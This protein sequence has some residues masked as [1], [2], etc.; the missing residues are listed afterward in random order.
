MGSMV[1][2]F[3][4]ANK[5]T[6]LRYFLIVFVFGERKLPLGYQRGISPLFDLSDAGKDEHRQES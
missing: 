5:N 2:V 3:S 1:Q 6:C 4:K